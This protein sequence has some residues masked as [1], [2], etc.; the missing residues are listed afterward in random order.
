VIKISF[1]AHEFPGDPLASAGWAEYKK[2]TWTGMIVS[3]PE[4]KTKFTGYLGLDDSSSY[5]I[6]WEVEVDRRG[7]LCGTL[8]DRTARNLWAARLDP[9]ATANKFD[10]TIDFIDCPICNYENRATFCTDVTAK[11]LK[12]Q[13]FGDAEWHLLSGTGVYSADKLHYAF[14]GDGFLGRII[15]YYPSYAEPFSIRLFGGKLDNGSVIKGY[16]T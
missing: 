1:P 8:Y 16:F 4:L 3:I 6:P 13:P 10:W 7:S 2:I 15:A 9:S 14:L 12:M 11:N 5:Y